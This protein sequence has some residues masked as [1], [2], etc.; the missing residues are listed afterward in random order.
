[1]T[2]VLAWLA[3]L[4]RAIFDAD[5]DAWTYQHVVERDFAFDRLWRN[6]GAFRCAIHRFDRG[7]GF[8]HPHPWMLAV[9]VLGPGRY[10]MRIAHDPYVEDVHA[11]DPPLAG[12]VVEGVDRYAILRRDV[13]HAVEVDGLC[14]TIMVA[15]STVPEPVPVAPTPVDRLAARARAADLFARAGV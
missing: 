14:Y 1:L 9:R 13:W 6:I 2:D 12:M 8:M 10:T 5:A 7:S 3:H 4:E 15:T 11:A